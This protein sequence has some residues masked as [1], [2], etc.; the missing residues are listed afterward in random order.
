[1]VATLRH[2][3]YPALSRRQSD[4]PTS[5]ATARLFLIA[6]AP[7]TVFCCV[8]LGDQESG[9]EGSV[10][11]SPIR[12]GPARVGVPNSAPLRNTQFV[13]ENAAGLVAAFK[14]DEAGRFRIPLPPGKYTIR[15]AAV[16][17]IGRCGPL[18]VEVDAVGFTTVQF[19]CDSGMR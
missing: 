12:G 8:V 9:I 19:N 16:K 15:T 2:V 11:I 17:R 7:L 4:L 3:N 10:S 5:M 18:A 14:T 6:L 1:M 13:V